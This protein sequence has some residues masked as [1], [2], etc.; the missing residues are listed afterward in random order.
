RIRERRG[1]TSGVTAP[2]N[3][4]RDKEGRWLV[5][6]GSSQSTVQRLFATMGQP[7]LIKDPRYATNERRLEHDEELVA[8]VQAW[9]GERSRDEVLELL[10][11]ADVVCGPVNTAADIVVDPH[12]VARS[13]VSG[14]SRFV[15]DLVAT[16]RMIQF[17]SLEPFVLRDSPGVAEHTD[18]VMADW[19]GS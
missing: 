16:G 19:L 4:Y 17:G 7:E 6:S 3:I 14:H 13:L 1:N 12:F 2:S 10:A 15:G 18:E 5:I 9:V 11:K 8:K